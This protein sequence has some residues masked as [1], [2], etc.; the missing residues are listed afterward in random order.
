MKVTL[1]RDHLNNKK[2]DKI[3][4]TEE[5]KAY[6]ERI[7]LIEGGK[8]KVEVKK[9]REKKEIKKPATKHKK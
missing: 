2:G 7:G 8:E 3:E 6:W 5:R 4:V 9:E 1:L